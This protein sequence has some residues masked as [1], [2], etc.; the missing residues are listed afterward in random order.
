MVDFKHHAVCNYLSVSE[1]DLILV[2]GF[3]LIPKHIYEKATI[4]RITSSVP[5]ARHKGS[6]P[7]RWVVKDSASLTGITAHCL[8]DKFDEGEIV[9]DSKIFVRKEDC[10]GDVEAKVIDK[11]PAF[12]IDF[13]L[14]F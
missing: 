3:K 1:P 7:N 12:T 14:L 2:A 11:L 13:K 8:T 6:T 4:G 10:W 9:L 5:I